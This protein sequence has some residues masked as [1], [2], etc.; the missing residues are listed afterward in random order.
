MRGRG[1]GARGGWRGVHGGSAR[2]QRGSLETQLGTTTRSQAAG[3]HRVELVA[4]ETVDPLEPPTHVVKCLWGGV[5][6]AIVSTCMQGHRGAVHMQM[7]HL[8]V[9][10]SGDDRG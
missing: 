5:F 6:M 7:L 8:G 2:R 3:M 4:R 1:R 9:C 10:V